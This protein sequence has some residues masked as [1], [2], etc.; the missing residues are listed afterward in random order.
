M[1]TSLTI[2]DT[3]F[4]RRIIRE[5][6]PLGIERIILFGSYAYGSPTI[7][8]DIDLLIVTSDNYIPQSF[9]EKKAINQR[10]NNALSFVRDQY[11]LDIIVYTY[12]MYQAFLLLDS[13][14]QREI[15]SK[16]VVLYEKNN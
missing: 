12:P 15:I 13:A 6:Q 4:T 7:D 11:A 9:S 1:E 10:V 5:L 2:K 8:S 16:G 3:G 14:F